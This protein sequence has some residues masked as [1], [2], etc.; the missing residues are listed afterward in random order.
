[1]TSLE[2][3][4]EYAFQNSSITSAVFGNALEKISFTNEFSSSKNLTFLIFNNCDIDK[5]MSNS[6][7]SYSNKSKWS[8]TNC[9]NLTSITFTG[10]APT[11]TAHESNS[12]GAFLDVLVQPGVSTTDGTKNAITIYTPI[13]SGWEKFASPLILEDTNPP[14]GCYGVYI[15]EEG[16]RKAYMAT[17]QTRRRN[18]FMLIIR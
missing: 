15:N 1:M 18:G 3:L 9:A 10:T 12:G 13:D 2:V 11:N 8:F 5:I 7:V 4:N 14:K 6:S 17:K 16:E